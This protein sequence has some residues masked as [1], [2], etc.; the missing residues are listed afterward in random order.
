MDLSLV[1]L[2]Q[3][4]SIL[5]H[6][7]LRSNNIAVSIS[8]SRTLGHHPKPSLNAH[9]HIFAHGPETLA[10]LCLDLSSISPC[11]DFAGLCLALFQLLVLAHT[12]P[13]GHKTC[14]DSETGSRNDG[15]SASLIQRL[16]GSEEEIG[17]KPV[18]DRR[19]AI[20]EGN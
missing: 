19:H 20:G 14:D 13:P 16:L 4:L 12:P 3:T 10:A 9:S 17:S 6:T 11:V 1:Y 7:M 5:S 18:R 2:L 15:S 8:T